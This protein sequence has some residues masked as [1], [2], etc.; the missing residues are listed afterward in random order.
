MHVSLRR[1]SLSL[2]I[3]VTVAAGPACAGFAAKGDAE[4]GV[5]S[6]HGML[7]A[8]RY[9]DIYGGTDDLFKNATSEGQFTAIL[10]AIHRKLGVVRSSTQTNFYSREQA[11]T[12]A[13]SYISMTY[14]TEF[15]EGPATESFNWRVVDG[16]VHLAGYNIQSDLLITR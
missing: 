6:F 12:N 5:A 8:E 16:R 9:S 7:D 2:A 10:Q 14:D 3:L 1:I 4:S 15:A 13:G 11:G